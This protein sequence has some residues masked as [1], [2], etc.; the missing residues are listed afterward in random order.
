MRQNRQAPHVCRSHAMPTRSPTAKRDACG[1]RASTLPITSWPGVIP[2][3]CTG[4]SP[5]ATCRS[6]RQTPQVST[7]I[8]TS[9]APGSGT[10]RSARRSGP[11]SIGPGAATLH[12]A[13]VRGIIAPSSP[14]LARRARPA[15]RAFPA[16]GWEV[17][18]GTWGD[19]RVSRP[20]AGSGGGVWGVACGCRPWARCTRIE[21]G[22]LRPLRSRW[23]PTRARGTQ[24]GQSL[25]LRSMSVGVPS[26][27]LDGVG[28]T[29]VMTNAQFRSV[30]R[31]EIEHRVG[32][33]EH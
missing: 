28:G 11:L 3:V 1:P 10:A 29:L 5:S 27:L 15:T 2:G 22:S 30:S 25:A 31:V 6:V 8:S 7:R 19:A 14:S 26:D 4:R 33:S 32:R 20:W 18:A 13:M 17:A 23:D 24:P 21:A 9:P 12:A 16:R